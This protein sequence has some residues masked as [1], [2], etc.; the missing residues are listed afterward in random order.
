WFFMNMRNPPLKDLRVRQ[1]IN[2]AVDRQ[3]AIKVIAE[4]DGVVGNFFPFE[5]WGVPR[6]ELLKMPGYRQPKDQ[7]IA[8]AKKLLA[9]AGYPNGF[10]MTILSRNNDLTRKSAVFMTDQLAKIGVTATVQVLEDAMFWDSGRKAQHQ[11]MVY[12]PTNF[13]ADPFFMGRFFA[14][15]GT[16]NFAGNDEDSKLSDLWEKQTRTLD[17]LERKTTIAQIERYL[18]AETLPAAPIVWPTSFIAMSPQE[19]GFAPGINDYSN[20]RHQETWLAQ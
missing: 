7:D 5:G 19:R 18:L 17:E 1:A 10:N 9:D 15:R 12:T 4:G 2:L 16:L 6:D 11:A 3:A 14:R 20:N 13:V 8:E